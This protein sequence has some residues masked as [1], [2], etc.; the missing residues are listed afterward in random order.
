VIYPSVLADRSITIVIPGLFGFPREIDSKGKSGRVAVPATETLLG[1]ADCLSATRGTEFEQQVFSLF[2]LSAPEDGDLPVAAVTR[3]LDL[4]VIDNGWWLRADPIHLRPERDRLVLLDSQAVPL[5]LEE[6]N[7]LTAEV[8]ES[9]AGD[10]WLLKS[11][12]PG[13]WY[14]KPP[15]AARIVT[16]PLPRVVGKDIHPYLPQGKDG[17]AWHTIL[18]EIQILLHTAVVNTEREQRGELPI[19]SLWFWGAGRLPRI[20][21]VEWAQVHSEEPITLALARLSEVPSGACPG[22]FTDWSRLAQ[23]AGPHL[24]VLDQGRGAVQYGL[25]REW[26]EFV[27]RLD[28]DWMVPLFRALKAREVGDATICTEVGTYH[29][30]QKQ[31]RRWWRR[32]RPLAG[33]P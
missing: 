29:I 18:N 33:F 28:R 21:Q 32:R 26:V 17:K 30:G 23:R 4:G 14:L 9:Y 1:R 11:P 15:R 19:N 6:A 5:R 10:G 25:E 8:L 3:A 20:N 24:V 27:E 22:N 7:R 31:I 13:R 2:G 12:R 16:T